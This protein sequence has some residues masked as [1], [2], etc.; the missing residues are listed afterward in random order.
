MAGAASEAADDV[1]VTVTS[2]DI[3]PTGPAS[4]DTTTAAVNGDLT[5]FNKFLV[6]FLTMTRTLDLYTYFRKSG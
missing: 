5:L 3:S 6:F 1:V 2:Q 4:K